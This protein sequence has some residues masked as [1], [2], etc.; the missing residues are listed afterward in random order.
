MKNTSKAVSIKAVW[1]F[2]PQQSWCCRK[3]RLPASEPASEQGGAVKG[4]AFER[5][6]ER[7]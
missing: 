3:Q 2:Q 6:E 5:I 1:L 4:W 7:G